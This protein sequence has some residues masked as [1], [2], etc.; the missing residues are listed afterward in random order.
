MGGERGGGALI[1]DRSPLLVPARPPLSLC[2]S[3]RLSFFSLLLCTP[4]ARFF[5]RGVGNR[6]GRVEGGGSAP[7]R[8]IG[9]AGRGSLPWRFAQGT[10]A[11]ALAAAVGRAASADP[12][13][14]SPHL[15]PSRVPRSSTLLCLVALFSSPCALPFAPA[16][17]LLSF[18]PPPFP[19]PPLE[20]PLAVPGEA[21]R[22]RQPL[23][24]L[25]L[26]PRPGRAAAGFAATPCFGRDAEPAAGRLRPRFVP[27]AIDAR[28]PRPLAPPFAFVCLCLVRASSPA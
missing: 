13:R 11:A 3:T 12:R 20:R 24:E 8:S 7:G 2:P 14:E 18:V 1:R 27:P 25:S 19:P 4:I 6:H 17:P 21:R 23:R 10:S 16:F 9:I 26:S 15:A 22:G 28:C 5:R